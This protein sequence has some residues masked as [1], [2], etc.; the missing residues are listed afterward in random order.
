MYHTSLLLLQVLLG[1]LRNVG[2]RRLHEDV[3]DGGLA[4]ARERSAWL[5][6]LLVGHLLLQLKRG[7]RLL[8]ALLVLAEGAHERHHLPSL[9]AT[10][11]LRA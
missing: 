5:L 10:G 8:L 1:V 9:G 6:L 4:A 2:R 11:L 3:G 7:R